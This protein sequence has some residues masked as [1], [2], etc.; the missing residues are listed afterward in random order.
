MVAPLRGANPST[1]NDRPRPLGTPA[2]ETSTPG[3]PRAPHHCTPFYRT[4]SNHPLLRAAPGEVRC[5]ACRLTLPHAAPRRRGR[6][7]GNL[8][9][10]KAAMAPKDKTRA[11]NISTGSQTTKTLQP[12]TCGKKGLPCVVD[13]LQPM[14]KHRPFSLPLSKHV[15]ASSLKRLRMAETLCLPES[16]RNVARHA[17]LKVTHDDS[18]ELHKCLAKATHLHQ[19]AEFRRPRLADVGQW[20][21]DDGQV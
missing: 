7:R 19:E 12:H 3:P 9:P 6:G 2:V 18:S 16:C 11:G 8:R 13:I 17:F 5:L 1:F 4:R 21:V 10:M 15:V 20:L 14:R